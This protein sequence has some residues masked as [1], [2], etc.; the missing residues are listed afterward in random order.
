VR[1]PDPLGF[2]ELLLKSDP[3]WTRERIEQAVKDARNRSVTLGEPLPVHLVYDTAWVDEAGTVQ[4]RNDVYRRD[5]REAIVA[6]R[7]GGKG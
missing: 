7:G 4:F 6:E 5:E 2:A 3:T 1:L